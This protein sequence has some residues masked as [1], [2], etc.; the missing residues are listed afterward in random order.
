MGM[1]HTLFSWGPSDWT[2]LPLISA[3]HSFLNCSVW[4]VV[5]CFLAQSAEFVASRAVYVSQRSPLCLPVWHCIDT[6]HVEKVLSDQYIFVQLCL[7]HTFIYWG[8][9]WMW[10]YCVVSETQAAFCTI[11]CSIW[12]SFIQTGLR[13]NIKHNLILCKIYL[14]QIT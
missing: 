10:L 14:Y 5:Q 11:T 6:V 8:M 9:D 7:A 12:V 13:G 1:T 4:C 2:H 3:S